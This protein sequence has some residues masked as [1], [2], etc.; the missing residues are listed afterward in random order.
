MQMYIIE[1]S[2]EHFTFLCA[3]DK[4]VIGDYSRSDRIKHAIVERRCMIYKIQSCI[5]GFLIFTTDF[6]DCSFIS[7]V[8]VKPSERRKGVATALLVDF[9]ERA[10]TAKIFSST[11][12]S[13]TKM[14][15]IFNATGFKRSGYIENLDDDDPEIIYFT[16]K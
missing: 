12:R 3:L 5:A 7:L 9:I 14:Q 8:I 6:F 2:M 10:P 13:N 16:L 15:N 11:N 4:E 1:A